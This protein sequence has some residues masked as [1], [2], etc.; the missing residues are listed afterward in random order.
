MI[1]SIQKEPYKYIGILQL[2][3]IKHEEVKTIAKKEHTL[4]S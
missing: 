3:H 2:N 4:K 1:K